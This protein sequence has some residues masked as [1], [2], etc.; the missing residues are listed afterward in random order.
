MKRK[1]VTDK[2]SNDP[3]KTRPTQMLLPDLTTI[4]YDGHRYKWIDISFG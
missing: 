2:Q 3:V 1:N 4:A